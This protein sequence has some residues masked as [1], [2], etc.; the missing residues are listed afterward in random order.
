MSGS[1]FVLHSSHSSCWHSLGNPFPGVPLHC[2][3][4]VQA[5]TFSLSTTI[6]INKTNTKI[7]HK[8]ASNLCL[9]AGLDIPYL[10][11]QLLLK[12]VQSPE[13][14]LKLWAILATGHTTHAATTCKSIIKH[15]QMLMFANATLLRKIPGSFNVMIILPSID[16]SIFCIS[17]TVQLVK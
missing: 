4:H 7:K 11:G 3:R 8:L 17:V 10:V 14:I 9:G 5:F 6:F 16:I 15:D 2:P 1:L 12:S 13:G